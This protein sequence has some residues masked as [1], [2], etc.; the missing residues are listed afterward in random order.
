M[1]AHRRVYVKQWEHQ[2]PEER[3]TVLVDRGGKPVAGIQPERIAWVDEEVNYWCKANHIHRWFVDN[4]MGGDDPNDGHCYR[5]HEY[6]L[7][8]LLDICSRVIDASKLVNGSTWRRAA[9][10]EEHLKGLMHCTAGRVIEDA[11]VAKELLPTSSGVFFGSYEYD[12]WYLNE[13]VE[14]REWA[15]QMIAD[16][17]VGG[18]CDELYYSSSW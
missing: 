7:R 5:I 13:V 18:L 12:E 4:V 16:M 8:K 1:Y 11:T 2:K 6:Q 3:Y 9:S 17:G 15:A 14:T 10:V